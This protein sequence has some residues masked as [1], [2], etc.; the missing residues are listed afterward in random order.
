MEVAYYSN[1]LLKKLQSCYNKCSEMFFK[2]DRRYSVTLMLSE[3]SLPF[4]NLYGNSVHSFCNRFIASHNALI[5]NLMSLQ[6]H[7]C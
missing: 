7:N 1:S 2:F 4:D 5:V 6:L 3:L